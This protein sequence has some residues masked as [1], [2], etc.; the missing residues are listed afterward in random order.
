MLRIIHCITDEKF[1]DCI[2]ATFDFLQDRSISRYVH[3][4]NN[5]NQQFRYL[6]KFEGV[7]Y[8][9]IS[10]FLSVLYSGDCDIVFLHNLQSMPLKFISKIPKAVKVVWLSWGFDIY[11][12]MGSRPLVPIPNL[13]QPETR[14]LLWDK[15]LIS[16]LKNLYKITRNRQLKKAVARVDY[17]SGII[18]EEYNMMS[19][20]PFFHA[21]QIDFRYATPLSDI[22][23]SLLETEKPVNGRNIL[24][25]NSGDPSNN[26]VDIFLKLSNLNLSE[27]YIYVPLSYG[28]DFRYIKKI[29]ELGV[30]LWGDYFVALDNFL[31]YNEYKEIIS[32]CGFRFFGHER[33]QALGNINLALMD[34]CKLF[35]SDTS[36]LW[37]HLKKMGINLY[38]IQKDIN[39]ECLS[40]NMDIE[41]NNENRKIIIED[42]LTSTQ[43]NR[44]YDMI[45]FFKL[46]IKQC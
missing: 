23:L 35:L 6:H 19:K 42:L 31:P 9:N 22:T 46:E 36:V 40:S 20:V 38:S 13:L 43:I 15:Q 39:Q 10:Q 33:Q 25:G 12:H 3:I 16:K 2:I 30:K 7:E 18:P 4:T 21:K 32:S 34:G 17:Y 28:D 45:E 41:K 29:K 26:H 27:R 5:A 1:V 11:G 24:I 8:V 14:K 44:L 37:R